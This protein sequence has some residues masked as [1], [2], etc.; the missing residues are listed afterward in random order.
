M[1]MMPVISLLYAF[2]PL[3]AAFLIFRKSSREERGTSF[4][5]VAGFN[6]GLFSFPLIEG[7]FGQKGLKLMAMF[8]FGNAFVIFGMVYLLGYQFSH[9]RNNKKLTVGNSVK[10][11]ATSVPFMGYI[12]AII[13]N[14]SHTAPFGFVS[15]ILDILARSN[16]ALS[17]LTLGLTLSFR[18][19]RKHWAFIVRIIGIRYLAGIISGFSLY[20]LLP[21]SQLIKT[22]LLFGL[23]LPVGLSSIP[24]S[25]EFGYD[26]E[27]TGTINNITIILSFLVM[28]GFMLLFPGI[29]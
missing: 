4:I 17:L 22:I 15:D 18:F 29:R 5:T 8:D 6:V 7:L 28:W 10:L 16:M 26:T 23:T 27:I 9:T 25:V 24:F 21:Y 3:S 20:L 13:L 11:L 2:I 19:D 1:L 14:I 12:L